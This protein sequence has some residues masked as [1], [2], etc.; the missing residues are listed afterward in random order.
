MG[1]KPSKEWALNYMGEVLDLF[2]SAV[3]A[4][5]KNIAAETLLYFTT[6]AVTRLTKGQEPQREL[7]Q[8]QEDQEAFID[9][10]G[11]TQKITSQA[12]KQALRGQH[13]PR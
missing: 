8:D 3:H 12:L 13:A 4:G 5:R 9:V 2:A 7:F 11:S 6:L 10:G 1:K